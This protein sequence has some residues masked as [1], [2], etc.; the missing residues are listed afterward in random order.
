M[1]VLCGECTGL[2]MRWAFQREEW[3]GVRSFFCWQASIQVSWEWEPPDLYGMGQEGIQRQCALG[4]QAGGLTRVVQE[5]GMAAPRVLRDFCGQFCSALREVS[6]VMLHEVS[7][8][9]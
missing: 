5:R 7:W 4:V 1:I 3:I 6:S 9:N 8:M 2:H